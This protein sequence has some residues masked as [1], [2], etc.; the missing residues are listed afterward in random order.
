MSRL[1][2]FV[3]GVP[4]LPSAETDLFTMLPGQKDKDKTYWTYACVLIALVKSD[5][6]KAQALTRS[7]STTLEELVQGLHAYYVRKGIQYDDTST[8]FTVMDEWGYK[9]I[10]IGETTWLNLPTKFAFPAGDYIFDIVEH[11]VAVN[12]PVDIREDRPSRSPSSR[13]SSYP[14]RTAVTTRAV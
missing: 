2:Q 6:A 13:A 14:T 3:P 9:P 10:F 8:R 1:D 4:D 5:Q 7:G 11:T 12:V